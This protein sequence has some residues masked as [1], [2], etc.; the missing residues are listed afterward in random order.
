MDNPLTPPLNPAIPPL[1]ST[2]P[3]FN[4]APLETKLGKLVHE[5]S[6][7]ELAEFVKEMNLMRASAQTRKVALT[8]EKKPKK[9]KADKGIAAAMALLAQLKG[10][11]TK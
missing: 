6:N 4:D 7:E 2:S 9:E 3:S 11:P 5:M 8:T 1:S 10:L